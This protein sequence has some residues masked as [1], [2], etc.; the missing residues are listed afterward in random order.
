MYAG[1]LKGYGNLV[2]IR[3]DGGFASA[4][5]RDAGALRVKRHDSV[6]T[7]EAIAAMRAPQCETPTCAS[8]WGG[9]TSRST[10]A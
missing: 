1:E 8:T 3:H 4:D 7:G 10:R 2:L 5:C 6:G 9:S